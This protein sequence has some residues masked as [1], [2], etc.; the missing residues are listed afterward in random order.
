M[1]LD[2]EDGR[3]DR[4]ILDRPSSYARPLITP[5]GDRVIFSNRQEG[6]AY[7]VGW[8]GS[9]LAPLIEGF[10]LDTLMDEQGVEW[11]YFAAEP[12]PVERQDTPKYSAIMRCP[13]DDPS[14]R[15]LVWDKLPIIELSECNFTVSADGRRASM[16]TIGL[17]GVVELPNGDWKNYGSGCWP[18]MAPDFSHR[19][20][21]FEGGHKSMLIYDPEG[22]N[23][24]RIIVS[25]APGAH[26][27]EVFHPRWSNHPRFITMTGPLKIRGGGPE[28]EVFIGR[29]ND[30][31]TDIV[32][33]ICVTDNMLA[34]GFPDVWVAS[35]LELPRPA[36]T[37]SAGE[38]SAPAGLTWPVNPEGLQFVWANRS[39]GNEIRT[40]GA[41]RIC[42]FLPR[43]RA[44]YGRFLDLRPAGGWFSAEAGAAELVEACRASGQFTMELVVTLEEMPSGAMPIMGSLAPDAECNFSLGVRDGNLVFRLKTDNSRD[45]AE[46]DL[47]P[48]VTGAP[49]H[50]VC[51][52]RS[53]SLACFVNGQRKA[54]AT[55]ITGG[56]SNWQPA[57]LSVGDAR[58]ETQWRG[59]VEGVAL[60]SRRLRAN[61]A[62]DGFNLHGHRLRDRRPAPRAVVDAKLMQ[63]SQ[64]PVLQDIAPYR[65]A[66]LGEV[67]ER[68]KIV[69]GA[70]PDSRFTVVR[71][72]LM[73]EKVLDGVARKRVAFT[74]LSSN[75]RR[76]IPSWKA[77]AW[78]TIRANSCFPRTTKSSDDPV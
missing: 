21:H 25:S 52:Y 8:D 20:W 41:A 37:A 42:R 39:G 55:N 77:S 12:R 4:A 35:A 69:D 17:C 29:F 30:D 73:D 14:R 11:L 64:L 58:S 19:F 72:V 2:S 23:R 66:L 70:I 67:Y 38:P 54:L 61:E 48:V 44:R 76:A 49:H 65:S 16:H 34:D 22:T 46:V 63:S 6:R 13:I 71:W 68:V 3:G 74:G 53:G 18:S 33:W 1:A 47:G 51:A 75:R 28:V 36:K 57:E 43:G 27:L 40:P 5:R 56:L 59:S 50:V 60:Y 7:I 24:T 26:G 10:A 78:S 31:F 45:G 62:R 32:E 15:E 9:G